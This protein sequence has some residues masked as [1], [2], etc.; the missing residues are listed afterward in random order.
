M[1]LLKWTQDQGIDTALIDPGKPGQNGTTESFNGKRRD[2]Y[3]RMEWFRNQIEA[4]NVVEDCRKH[5]NEVHPRPSLGY[6]P[7]LPWVLRHLESRLS[8]EAKFQMAVASKIKAG[9]MS[10]RLPQKSL[11]A[12]TMCI[13]SQSA[14]PAAEY[15]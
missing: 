6:L 10:E 2:E 15:L 13:E 12:D 11:R 5:D 4:T 14:V 7:P 9:K 3:L 8:T 1:A